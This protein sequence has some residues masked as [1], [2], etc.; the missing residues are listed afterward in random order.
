MELIQN[1]SLGF[2]EAATWQNLLYCFLGVTLGNLL[3]V[4]PGVGSVAAVSIL[5]PVTYHVPPST[6]LIILAGL[7]YGAVYGAVTGAI[8]L[9]IPHSV[10]AI[11]CLD[12]YPMARQGRA[13]V[14]LFMTTMASLSGSMV[15]IVILSLFAPPL[16]NVAL[17][18]GSPEYFALVVLAMTGAAVLGRG[19][20]IQSMTSV[21]IGMLIGLVGID[22]TS[23]TPRFTFD[24][25]YL[26]DGVPISVV[27]MGLF[28]IAELVSNARM[29]PAQP[30][31]RRIS[32]RDLLPSREEFSR[33]WRAIL[34]GT[35]VGSTLG[36]L[37]GAGPV[38][39][40]IMGYTVERQIS[41]RPERFGNGAIEGVVAPEAAANAA[42]QV[43]FVPT[44]TLGIPADPIM[45]IMLS[46]L[47]IKGISPGPQFITEHA[48][49]FWGLVVSFVIGNVLLVIWHV[50]FIGIWVRLLSVPFHILFPIVLTF[51]SIG[52][53]S[54]RQ[55][56]QDVFTMLIFGGIGYLLRILK[57]PPAPLLVGLVLGPEMEAHLRR[58]LIVSHGDP[59]IFFERGISATILTIALLV[60]IWTIYGSF[61]TR[62]PS[63]GAH[64]IEMPPTA[65]LSTAARNAVPDK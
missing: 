36:L 12:G 50:P 35:G 65:E 48:D 3:G 43:G 49:L 5:L 20:A 19:A 27:A 4:L 37:P 26:L 1:L 7:Y 60:L 22:T 31:T 38:L 53:Y 29:S 21:V 25:T 14:A 57:F 52:I 40:S 61:R 30:T 10:S 8:L 18:F 58:S 6:G 32:M 13:G 46:A 9:N 42:C 55:S 33:S 64:A 23:G 44:L 62:A 34:R 51:M 15:G 59:R 2:S 54:V 17:T 28:G 47:T 63:R 56:P 11:E 24:S 45:A 39:A 41:R 16:S